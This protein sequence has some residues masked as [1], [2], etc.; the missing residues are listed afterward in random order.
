M[1]HPLG[2]FHP[3]V[4]EPM[5]VVPVPTSSQSPPRYVTSKSDSNQILVPEE[6]TIRQLPDGFVV[7]GITKGKRKRISPEQL[8]S[9]LEVFEQTDTPSS[10]LREELAERL[11]MS[12]REVQVWFQNRRAK[13]SRMRNNS[14]DPFEKH[15]KHRR[16]STSSGSFGIPNTFV[17]PPFP[18]NP[19]IINDHRPRRYSAV[20]VLQTVARPFTN[21]QSLRPNPAVFGIPHPPPAVP[22]FTNAWAQDKKHRNLPHTSAG[23]ANT[24]F[25]NIAPKPSSISPMQDVRMST[26]PTRPRSFQSNHDSSYPSE[27]QMT[28]HKNSPISMLASAAEFVSSKDAAH[29][30]TC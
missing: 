23:S 15:T 17:P 29:P 9:L 24:S 5:N 20:P 3:N 22:Q 8:K 25:P 7:C 2:P 27:I 18:A 1:S 28:E 10:Q 6:A 14:Q 16:K 21:I 13:A 4:A 12:K 11:N 26:P 19:A 30:V